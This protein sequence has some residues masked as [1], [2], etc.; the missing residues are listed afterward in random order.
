VVD[1]L[2]YCHPFVWVEFKG[3]QEKVFSLGGNV[4]EDL[5]ERFSWFEVK[6]LYVMLC[7][8]VT[9]EIN[10]SGCSND[11]KNDRPK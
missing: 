3:S 10:L 1:G 4:F 2:Q 7:S 5:F 11:A 8:L 6:R 9:D